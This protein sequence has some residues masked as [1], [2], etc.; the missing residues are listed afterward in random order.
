MVTYAFVDG[1]GKRYTPEIARI[2][3]GDRVAEVSKKFTAEAQAE[4]F[5]GA[6]SERDANRNKEVRR[7]WQDKWRASCNKRL[8]ELEVLLPKGSDRG[9]IVALNEGLE[10]LAREMRRFEIVCSHNVRHEEK[11]RRIAK[12][13]IEDA[14]IVFATLSGAATVTGPTSGNHR[15]TP[16]DRLFETVVIDEAAQAT[17]PACL[18]P[19]VLGALRCLLVGDPQQLPATVFTNGG[20]GIAYSQSL[21]ER[22]CR[23]GKRVSLLTVQYRMHPAISQ[24]PSK[25]FYQSRVIDDTSVQGVGRVKPYH[26]KTYAPRF[27]PYVFIDV[28]DGQE[29][30]STSDPSVFNSQEADLAVRIYKA[31]K[32]Q[33][34]S[35]GMFVKGAGSLGFGVITPYK[36]QMHHLRS[37]FRQAGVP[38]GDLEIDTVDAF[39]GREKDFVVFS[40]VRTER[41]SGIG[42]VRDIRRMNVGLT[43]ARFSCVILG[44]GAALSESKDWKTLIQDAKSRN[45]YLSVSSKPGQE[46]ALP[47]KRKSLSAKVENPKVIEKVVQ[48]NTSSAPQTEQVSS[49]PVQKSD[50]SMQPQTAPTMEAPKVQATEKKLSKGARKRARKRQQK[51]AAA[52]AGAGASSAG[53]A[54]QPQIPTSNGNSWAPQMTTATNGANQMSGSGSNLLLHGMEQP[55]LLPN[56][57]E[58]QPQPNASLGPGAGQNY[59]FP[60]GAPDSNE[61]LRILNQISST[62]GSVPA[63]AFPQPGYTAT[64]VVQPNV[65]Q[66]TNQSM[67]FGYGPGMQDIGQLQAYAAATGLSPDAILSALQAH[68]YR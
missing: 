14:Q 32:Q 43:R 37:A 23:A 52:A 1:H 20:S 59:Q 10:R 56:F 13:Y 58:S 6:L 62:N 49:Q 3:G 54:Q 19:L 33:F 18:I 40:C 9:R 21:L 39:Q 31:L 66:P 55:S 2:G 50:D 60:V 17:E 41:Q 38:S 8:T 44:N 45:C 47:V 64:N 42:F 36:R 28:L 68:V 61:L 4:A 12:T 53:N 63:A 25:H 27:G 65:S 29:K 11:V 15:S 16:E 22:M 30:R 7:V 24:F 5:I 48:Q 46:S 67:A 51:E 26:D 34:P 57:A 35:D